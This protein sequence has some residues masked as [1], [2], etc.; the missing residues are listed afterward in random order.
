MSFYKIIKLAVAMLVVGAMAACTTPPPDTRAADEA[1]LRKADADWA[2]TAQAR[3]ASGWISYYA[4]YAMVMP[5][6]SKPAITQQD[7]ATAIQGLMKLPDLTIGWRPVKVEVSRAGDLA[8]IQGTYDLS[9][10]GPKRKKVSDH[11][12]YIEIWRKQSDGSWKC[13]VDI[14]NS[15]L[16]S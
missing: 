9:F 14:W 16:S 10:T 15:D 4:A 13:I 11:G 2:A 6:N 3:N 1:A 5:P 7:I 8:Y 12:K